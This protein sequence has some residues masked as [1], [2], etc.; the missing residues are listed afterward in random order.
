M[1]AFLVLSVAIISSCRKDEQTIGL[2]SQPNSDFL[3]VNQDTISLTAVLKSTDSIRTNLLAESFIGR[4]RD[5]VFGI[6]NTVFYAQLEL[7]GS[8]LDLGNPDSL[9]VDSVVLTLKTTGQIHG[10]P[11]LAD[12]SVFELSEPL[13]RDTTYYSDDVVQTFTNDLKRDDVNLIRLTNGTQFMRSDSLYSAVRI[14]LETSVGENWLDQLGTDVLANDSSFQNFFR[15]IAVVTN[16]N[17]AVLGI[18]P[19]SILSAV[20]IYYRDNGVIID[21]LETSFQ[22]DNSSTY[23]NQIS[24]DYSGT[25]FPDLTIDVDANDLIYLQGIGGVRAKINFS[26]LDLEIIGTPES[27][28]SKA[29]LI[30]PINNLNTNSYPPPTNLF[31]ST[32]QT[33]DSLTIIIDQLASINIGGTLDFS[34]EQYVFNCTQHIQ[35]I[36]LGE[37]DLKPF[38]LSV[39]PPNNLQAL[40]STSFSSYNSALPKLNRVV[41]NGPLYELTDPVQNM[42]LVVTYSE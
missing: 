16:S 37:L 25:M 35:R 29:E 8:N 27:V 18:D 14:P 24:H 15:G 40:F 10:V 38:W 11:Y 9:E 7:P 1:T 39:N 6:T 4:Y 2:S 26:A 20:N 3:S 13:F 33:S 42:R 32:G 41:L 36:L 22:I 21:T 23:F 34:N 5:P 12:I 30:M 17:G 19:N 31:L 28:L